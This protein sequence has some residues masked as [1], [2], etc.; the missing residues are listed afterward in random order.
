MITPA[1]S[2]LSAPSRA[3]RS[4]RRRCTRS[5]C[6]SPLV[7][8]RSRCSRS[9]STARRRVG[10]LFGPVMC[11]W[12]VALAV[13][14]RD[15][16]SSQQPGDA[17]RRSIPLYAVAFVADHPL[18]AFL[19]LGAVVLA[20]T[21]TEALYADMGHF[22]ASPIRRAWL[23]FVMPGARAQLLRPGR[24]ASSPT[25]TAIKNPFYLLAP[26]WALIPLRRARDLRD[27]HRLAGGDL[28]R[29]L[30]H[31]RRRSRWATARASQIEHTSERADR[32]DL[33]AV[34]QLVA[35]RRGDAAGRRLPKLRAPGGRVR[36][37]GHAG[38]ADRL[39]PDLRRDAAPLELAAVAGAS[40]SRRRS[41]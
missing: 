7:D 22:G 5:S 30:A 24:A 25:P 29:V 35:V 41:R 18:A 23:F 31:A 9:R 26:S 39:D 2:V 14:G 16:R 32:P 8:H 4:S 10:M 20:V 21:G 11:L 38:D 37:R 3:S 1:I 27:G 34:H 15:A 40:R 33:R 36:H 12:F 13:L 28:G 19:A 6:R 17:A